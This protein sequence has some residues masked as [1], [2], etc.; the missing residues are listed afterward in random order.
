MALPG[1]SPPPPGGTGEDGVRN[2]GRWIALILTVSFAL[3]AWIA[4]RGGQLFWPDEDRF[5]AVR[6]IAR[7]LLGGEVRAA[8]DALLGHP[9]H[10]LFKA[11][12]LLPASLEILLGTPGWVSALFFGL[13]STWVLWLVARVARAAGASEEESLVALLLAACTTSLFYYSRHY[14]PYDLSLGLLLLSLLAGLPEP[15]SRRHSLSA[16]IWAGLGFLC[17]NGYWTLAGA[18]LVVHVLR[19]FPRP[20]DMFVRAVWAAVG[21]LLPMLAVAAIS[22]LLGHDF[23]TLSLAL[24]GT[25]TQGDLGQAWRF[26]PQYLWVTEHGLALLWAAGLLATLGAGMRRRHRRLLLWPGLVLLVGAFLIVPSDGLHR[27]A[28]AARHVRVLLPILCLATAAALCTLVPPRRRTLVL[29]GLLGL[30]GLQAAWNFTPPLRQLFPREFHAEAVRFL[31]R[32][33]QQDLG[34]YTIVNATFLHNPDW[35]PAAP[36]AGVVL[37][38]RQHPFQFTPYLYEGYTATTRARYQARDLSMRIVRLAVGGP[39]WSGHPSGMIEMHLRFPEKPFGLLPEPLL[40]TGQPGRGDSLFVRFEGEGHIRIGHDNTGRGAT[41]SPLLPLD[42]TKT[43]RLRVNLG[44]FYPPDSAE[45]KAPTFVI[46][47][48]RIAL[49][50]PHDLHPSRPE[51]LTL[52]HNFIGATTSLTQLSA[53]I[54]GFR[55]MPYPQRRMVFPEPP[56]ALR[57]EFLPLVSPAEPGEAEPL[58]SSGGPARGDLLFLRNEGPGRLRVGHYHWGGG[59]LW[60]EPLDY[61]PSRRLEFIVALAPFL[62]ATGAPAATQPAAG[63]LYV[64]GNGRVLLNRFTLFHPARPGELVFGQNRVIVPAVMPELI[65]ELVTSD[66]V[67][68]TTLSVPGAGLPGPLRLKLRFADPIPRGVS[69]PLLSTGVT[70]AGDLLFISF[71]E[72]GHYRIGHDHWGH[73]AVVSP[74]RPLDPTRPLELTVSLGSLLPSATQP[75]APADRLRDRLFVAVGDDILLDRPGRFHPAAESWIVGLNS[76]GAS[77]AVEILPADLLDFSPVSPETILSRI[78]IP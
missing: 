61:D 59:T 11:A 66:P 40:S 32:A 20:G 70:G 8:V 34:P 4:W 6:S 63:R 25:V 17:Y 33:R 46:W 30:V 35:A 67:P 50:K 72:Q 38:Q 39:A 45:G 18:A 42:R 14:F 29:S 15:A 31:A 55:R 75:A 48:E 49:L 52:G 78:K 47:N 13:A 54:V 68:A 56:G 22:R 26:V 3:R 43:H 10:L 51:D 74:A 60:S 73:P 7:T 9:D 76:L 41:Y 58:L 5:E 44:N 16:G 62:P 19:A 27:F 1:Q 23:F 57:F 64:S 24:A 28:L 53:E 65:S 21:L 77:S 37:V 12:S 69:F 71:D 36:D 2:A